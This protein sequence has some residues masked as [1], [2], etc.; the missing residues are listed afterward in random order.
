MPKLNIKIKEQKPNECLPA[1]LSAVFEYYRIK[2]SE[3]EIIEKISKN[4][5]KLYDWDFQAG[6]LTIEKGL[7][8]E[9]YSNVPQLFDPSWHVISQSELIRKLEK[10]LEFF[11]SRSRNFENDSSLM[12]FMCPNKEV[13]NRL[14]RDAETSLE[15]LK[16]GG[17][18]N[19]N[20]ISKE[21]IEKITKADIPVI[22]SHSPTLLHRMKR[23]NNFQPDDIKGDTWG[24]YI[25]ISG[26]TKNKFIISDPA[27]F[28]Y[29]RS[30][31]Y[32]VNKDL[33]LESILRF[34][35]QLLV[36]KK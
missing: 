33:L 14:V 11:K 20:P 8:A 29:E 19:F 36:I 22:I 3:K 18:I 34:S 24:H 25:I 2:I 30:L 5:F 35:G 31:V 6:K 17:T 26:Y 28:S 13:A 16:A 10:S 27:G 12:S 7:K 4:S 9:I 15:F 32:K 1:C 23:R 21:L